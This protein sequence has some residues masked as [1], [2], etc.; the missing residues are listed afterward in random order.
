[1]SRPAYSTSARIDLLKIGTY[2]ARDNQTAAIGFIDRIEQKCEDLADSP[3]MGFAC[4][5]LSPGLLCWPVGNYI[6]Y[7]RTCDD[8]IEVVRVLHGARDIPR[9]FE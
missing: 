2:I 3:D 6:I 8:G 1:M 5:D 7:F 9:E 4:D